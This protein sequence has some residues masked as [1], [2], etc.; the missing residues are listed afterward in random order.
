MEKFEET[1][2]KFN[3]IEG[4]LYLD[5]KTYLEKILKKLPNNEIFINE[6]MSITVEYDGGNHPEYDSNCFSQVSKVYLKE[7]GKVYL[8]I[9]ETDEYSIENIDASS[10]YGVANA[11]RETILID[12][13]FEA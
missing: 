2:E 7:N 4:Q 8:S 11:V 1:F 3:D 5:C 9:E 13:E 6:D 12:Y 10:L